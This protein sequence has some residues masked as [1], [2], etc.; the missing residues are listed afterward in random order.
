MRLDN[1][2]ANDADVE[3]QCGDSIVWGFGACLE[4][5]E[6]ALFEAKQTL[7]TAP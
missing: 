6:R 3:D 5:R 2:D 4:K 7:G 1:F